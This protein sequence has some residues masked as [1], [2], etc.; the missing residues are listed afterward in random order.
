M[1]PY[2]TCRELF[3][4]YTYCAAQ[5]VTSASQAVDVIIYTMERYFMLAYLNQYV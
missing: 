4:N 1:N 3:F 2:V 5:M